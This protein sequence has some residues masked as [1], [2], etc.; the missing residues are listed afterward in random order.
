MISYSFYLIGTLAIV[1][2][3]CY[4]YIGQTNKKQ[5]V[6]EGCRLEH[7]KITKAFSIGLS[8]GAFGLAGI[9]LYII[10]ILSPYQLPIKKLLTGVGVII[11]CFVVL[12]LWFCLEI[13]VLRELSCTLFVFFPRINYQSKNF[14]QVS[15]SSLGVLS[16]F[17]YGSVWRSLENFTQSPTKK[18]SDIA[19][20][21]LEVKY[22][23]FTLQPLHIL[24][25]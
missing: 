23:S 24:H 6:A 4:Y 22:I 17:H 19:A 5:N 16:S 11:G 20:V 1:S 25:V 15:E 12:P 3:M 18:L 14:L 21:S 9:V 13:F 10:C 7:T 2:A 8:V